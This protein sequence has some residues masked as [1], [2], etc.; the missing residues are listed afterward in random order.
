VSLC[1]TE[2]RPI[3]YSNRGIYRGISPTSHC[4]Y[5]ILPLNHCIPRIFQRPNSN[6]LSKHPRALRVHLD[7]A[8]FLVV[9]LRLASPSFHLDAAAF[10]VVALRLASPSAA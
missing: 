6:F 8:A 4:Y 1:S 10:L 9:A 2:I 7:A 5:T 3:S